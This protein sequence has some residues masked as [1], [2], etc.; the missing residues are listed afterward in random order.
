MQELYWESSFKKKT[1]YYAMP[2]VAVKG[3]LIVKFFV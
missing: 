1:L 2:Y 3:M